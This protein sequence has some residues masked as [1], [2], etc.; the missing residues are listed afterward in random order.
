MTLK[1]VFKFIK[2]TILSNKKKTVLIMLLIL[3]FLRLLLSV[4]APY[5]LNFYNTYD[6]QLAV[7]LSHNILMGKW[8]GI[9]NTT[10]LSKGVSYP[11]FLAILIK[12][13]IPYGI[14]LGLFNIIASFVAA[15]SLFP[16]VKS[17][18]FQSFIYLTFLYS[19]VSF[20]SEYSTRLYRNSIIVPTVIIVIASLIGVYYRKFEPIKVQ[21]PWLVLLSCSFT[22]FWFIREDSLWLLP[23]VTG[24]LFITTLQVWWNQKYSINIKN[25][26]FLVK[27]KSNWVEKSQRIIFYVLPII[28][29][30]FVH[31]SIVNKNNQVYGIPTINDRT[32]SS[33]GD[34]TKL[35]IKI[36]DG[37]SSMKDDSRIWVSKKSL[38][39]VQS[40]SPTFRQLDINW[41]YTQ[42]AWANTGPGK[43]ISGD[44]VFWGLREAAHN[45]SYYQNNGRKTEK[46]WFKVNQ[47]IET[48]FEQ[49]KLK[50][51]TELQLS[52][53]G[54]GKKINDLPLVWKFM[55]CGLL[56]NLFYYDYG[57]G[58]DM[59]YGKKENIQKLEDNLNI[60][61]VSRW[62]DINGTESMKKLPVVSQISNLIISCYQLFSKVQIIFSFFWFFVVGIRYTFF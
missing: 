29:L 44:L 37:T 20:T 56:Y 39:D 24:G 57:Q 5:Y 49:K 52:S 35:L 61:L 21:I 40:I 1:K 7:R 15:T 51:K 30:V 36:D 4:Y 22:F 27:N 62:Y 18:L 38:E 10:T 50:K 17:R 23:L 13:H 34:L 48:A 43:E 58:Y 46:F 33:F 6:D 11:L 16:L 59:V 8:L 60:S 25:I 14:F 55:K 32:S 41:I 53:K 28:C 26:K 42:S 54:D 47:E 19:P 2:D 31:N 9:Y 12:Y 3:T 45:N